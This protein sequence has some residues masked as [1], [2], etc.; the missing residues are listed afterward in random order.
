[1]EYDFLI[2]GAGLYGAVCGEQLTKR[3]KKVLII[4]RR[5]HIGGN[6]YTEK[7]ENIN[8]H[9]YGAHIFHTARKDIWEYVNRFAEMLPYIHCPKA[10][11]KGKYY[12]LPFNMNTFNEIWGVKEEREVKDIINN[13]IKESN[14]K[15]PQNLEEQAIS[16]VGKDIYNI[17]IKGYTEKQ[18]GRSCDKLPP[19][20]IK[21]IPVRFT[22]DNNYFNDAYQGIPQNGYTK[23]IE[24]MIEGIEVITG[25]DYKSFILKT[26]DTF[27][28]VIYTG[29]IDEYYDYKL[30]KL[31]YRTIYFENKVYNEN[32]YQERSVI[33]YTDKEVPYTRII[34]HKKFEDS[35]SLKT[36]VSFEYSKKWEE[37]DEPYYPVNDVINNQLYQKYK[38]LNKDDNI[39]FGGRLG[40]YKYYDM[41]K[42]I[43]SALEYCKEIE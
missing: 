35:I 10:F 39:H 8:V 2:V 12:S 28:N 7:M 3:G 18:W 6:V 24:K 34:E 19:F 27:K 36:V 41:D 29:G 30:G 31:E 4:D 25:E 5:S 14:I 42:V 21:R 11:Y 9:K 43:L 33:N 38:E 17:L 15:N 26:K 23:M 22:F 16:L 32:S 1:M 13:Q 37:G 40:E 20:I